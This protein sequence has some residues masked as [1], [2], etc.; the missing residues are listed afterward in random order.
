MFLLLTKR[1][2]GPIK[3][4]VW[5]SVAEEVKDVIG[6]GSQFISIKAKSWDVQIYSTIFSQSEY[7]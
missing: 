3:R 1:V 6:V 5:K 2:L 4:T 7:S